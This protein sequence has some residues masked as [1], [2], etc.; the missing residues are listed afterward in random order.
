MECAL[1]DSINEK[2]ISIHLF[3]NFKKPNK[4]KKLFTSSSILW[5]CFVALAMMTSQN[6]R[7][8]YV[9]LT[10]L[11]GMLSYGQNALG[12]ETYDK[13]VDADIQTK[14]GGWFNPALS[15]EEAWPINKGESANRMWIIV[16]AEKAVVPEWYFLVTGN[17]T[18][19]G[20]NPGERNWASWKIYGGNFANDAD[21]VRNGEGWTLLDDKVDEPLPAKNFAETNLQ[22]DYMGTDEFQYFWIE[23]T[24]SV[25]DADIYL[26]MSEWGLGSYGDFQ[27]YLKWLEDQGTGTDEP[28]NYFS[29]GGA[30]EGFGGE[31][32]GNLFDGKTD[33]KW[34][35]SFTNRNEGETTN[36]GYVLIKASRPIAPTYYTLTTANDT[37]SNPGR[38][39]KQW[40]IYG[41]N[42]YDEEAV[43]RESED[44]VLIDSKA[45]VPT[46]TGLN[47]LPAANFTQA[48]FTLTDAN[49][50][51]FRYFKVEIDQVVSSG[52]M[53]MAELSFGDEYVVVLQGKAIADAAEEQFDP[54]LIAEKALLDQM[55]ELIAQVRACTDPIQLSELSTAVDEMLAKINASATCYKELITTRNQAIIAIENNKVNDEAKAY[56]TTWISE[57]DAV[58]P[59]DEYPCGNYA[60]IV[61]N[62]LLS[63]E[64]AQAESKRINAY[65]VNHSSEEIEPIY[66]TYEFLFGTTDNWNASEGPESLIDG[67]PLTTKWG[68]GTSGDRFIIFKSSEPIQ[69]TYYGL[70][71]GGD[72]DTYKDR[73]WKNWKIWA[74]NFD[75]GEFDTETEEGKQ[76]MRESDKWVLIDVKENIGTDILKTTNCFESYIYLSEGCAEPY[77]YFKIEVYHQ[78]GMQMNEFTFYNTGNMLEYREG[79]VEEFEGYDARER[80]AYGEYILSYESK[81]QELTTTVYA[82]DVMKFKNELVDLQGL[83]DASGDLYVDYEDAYLELDAATIESESLSEWW[84]GYSTENVAPCSK[85]IRGTH[86]NIIG[87]TSGGE[88]TSLGTL[89]DNAIVAEKD[90]LQWIANAVNPDNDCHYILLGGNNVGQW[91]DGFYGH[92]IDGI[93]LNT[94]E[95]DEETGEEKEVNATKWGGQADPNGNTYI[96]FRT[97]DKTSPF[98][99]TLTTGND[100]GRFPGRNWGT[101]YIYGANFEGDAD[102][103][104]DAEGWT[105]I[106][107][108]E[109]VGQDRLHP[110]NA[111]PSYFGFSEEQAEY[112]YYKVVVTKAYEGNAIQMNEIYFGTPEEFEAIKSQYTDN[113]D[114]FDADGYRAQQSLIEEYNATVPEIDGCENM[115]ALFVVNYKLESLRAA[116]EASAAL[117]D[118]LETKANEYA[119]E[120]KSLTESE[121]LTKLL[122]YITGDAAEPTEAYPHGNANYILD[123]HVL[124]DS[125]MQVELAFLEEMHVAAVAAG[126][127]PGMDITS[128]IKNPTFAKAGDML[129]NEKNENIGREAEGWDGYIYRTASD[130]AEDNDIFAAEFCNVNAKFDV[131]Q[132]LT[133][134]KNGFYKVTLN[135]GYRANG[136]DKMLS[137]NYAAMAYANEVATYVPVIRED[138]AETED[139]AWKG[140]YPDKQIYSADSTETYGWG[141]WG[142]EGAAHAFAQGRYAI[143]MVAKVTDGTLTIGVKN[144]GTKGNEWTAVGNFGLVYLGEES[145][146]GFAEAFGEVADYNAERIITLT[147]LYESYVD[148]LEDY[149]DA[150]N[151]SAAQKATLVANKDVTTY[152]AEVIIGETMKAI[153]YTKQAYNALFDASQ[154][155]YGK[156]FERAGVD[157]AET[158]V[159]ETR[160]GLDQGVY[161]D[162]EAAKAA[163]AQLYTDFPDYLEV[164]TANKLEFDQQAFEYDINTTGGRAYL[165]LK[166][167]YEPLEED[168]VILTF[169]YKSEKDIENGKVYYNTPNFMTD[170]VEEFATMPIAEDWTTVYVNV[171]R[172]VKEL[173]LGTAVDHGIRWYINYNA[174]TDDKLTLSARNFH[175][176][177]KAQMKAEGGKVINAPEGDVNGDKLLNVADAQAVLIGMADGTEDKKYDVNGDGVVN[178]ADAQQVLILMADD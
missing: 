93:A 160:D 170:V 134:L 34:C 137:Y 59:N 2:N 14:W 53:Q 36:G 122:G 69:P 112:M 84:E 39:W 147:E 91:G 151:F 95:I 49:P 124:N 6:A 171:K 146:D 71:T 56:L 10:A 8:E 22:F 74:A 58:A 119:E 108:K 158:A 125:V 148:E 9:K 52:L 19:N 66:A 70:V 120:A 42:A 28:I 128:L 79:F 20:D 152:E 62:R 16:K 121:A 129:K 7:A 21:A 169:D 118:E 105:L 99:Y 157:D 12:A 173:G 17:D 45:G 165:D 149:S 47:E 97:Q 101:W 60:Y 116:I 63:G 113:A 87:I 85:Y 109:N 75:E 23:I 94:T 76:A 150:P 55:A 138:A 92:L 40:R 104:K 106:D 133:D 145:A 126:Y 73:N 89:D 65:I 38:N 162:A 144:E 82:P 78:G 43:T 33:T 50:T 77:E 175:F 166:N 107:K 5:M 57:T 161:D 164:A 11:D 115:E 163:K 168:E 35:C 131:S 81:Y 140:T 155:V 172:G 100:T 102:A 117:Y 72:T 13:L 41:M 156:W 48:Y 111:E 103:T 44:W 176:I 153:Y 24:K 30:P 123:N 46:G 54:N 178:I 26:Q 51:Q 114:D 110:V 27:K 98:F 143:T 4:M 18:G 174:T 32:I 136:D 64:Q 37:Q 15:D 139:E 135:A 67:D 61:A 177:T 90:Y 141:I 80:V 159:Y 127:G 31:G 86:D 167:L 130:G 88:E 142:S 3:I 68:T 29:K 1:P 83:I 132:T 96:I 154:K 25:A